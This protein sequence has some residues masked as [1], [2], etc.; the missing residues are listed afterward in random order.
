MRS[1]S[2]WLAL[3]CTQEMRVAVGWERR[4]RAARLIGLVG[5][6]KP[7]RSRSI[8]VRDRREHRADIFVDGLT[9]EP[10]IVPWKLLRQLTFDLD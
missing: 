7:W 6:G 2:R 4:Q 10:Q 1:N 3:V 9:S 5:T 8:P